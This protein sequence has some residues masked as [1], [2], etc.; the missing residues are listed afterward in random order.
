[1]T[2]PC[3]CGIARSPSGHDKPDCRKH[4]YRPFKNAA[5]LRAP[6]KVG[7]QLSTGIGWLGRRSLLDASH[8]A[9][10]ATRRLLLFGC[11]PLAAACYFFGVAFRPSVNLQHAGLLVY[12]LVLGYGLAKVAA[13]KPPSGLA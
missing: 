4:R 11:D 5:K 2:G 8:L 13:S 10:P 3:A 1:M 7:A 9:V 12:G 6:L